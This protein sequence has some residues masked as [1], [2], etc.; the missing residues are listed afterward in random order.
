MDEVRLR[1]RSPTFQY[2]NKTNIN[3]NEN[4]ST[5]NN[6][7]SKAISGINDSEA[8]GN[9]NSHHNNSSTDEKTEIAPE[10]NRQTN[11][12]ETNNAETNNTDMNNNKNKSK[13]NSEPSS[14]QSL[15]DINIDEFFNNL[16][17]LK[18]LREI[19]PI[20]GLAILNN[21]INNL[22]KLY[23]LIQQGK[24]KQESDKNGNY[25][26]NT[27][28]NTVFLKDIIFP[29]DHNDSN[30][31][32]LNRFKQLL[33]LKTAMDCNDSSNDSLLDSES[34][35]VDDDNGFESDVDD[36]L[37]GE[38]V[39]NMI[40]NDNDR[41]DT[42]RGNFYDS[43]NST[44]SSGHLVN[45]NDDLELPLK[46]I[47]KIHS[48]FEELTQRR[49]VSG[50]SSQAN[51]NDINNSA[52]TKKGKNKKTEKRLEIIKSYNDRYLINKS[53]THEDCL[54]LINRFYLKSLP[55]LPVEKYL[56]RINQF[57]SSSASVYITASMYLFN[58]AFNLKSGIK[59]YYKDDSKN[60]DKKDKYLLI[61]PL[62]SPESIIRM[63]PIEDL[64]IFRLI[65][66]SIRISSKLIEDKNYKQNYYCKITGLQ[67][68]N[69]LF[70]LELIFLFIIDFN[71]ITNEILILRHLYQLKLFNNNLKN[72]I[73]SIN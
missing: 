42:S 72:F 26:S 15:E 1:T 7:K 63:I 44:L 56:N 65:L 5:D 37:S 46:K 4:E 53:R 32:K 57:I 21:T 67:N 60:Y 51:I 29:K 61:N 62:K 73:N 12:I 18:D 11:D 45:N 71:L 17:D 22:K 16:D 19:K 28:T 25:D 3:I 69:E 39:E 10:P 41:P 2:D 31:I 33:K 68:T 20:E 8:T 13:N 50:N 54:Q 55:S 48:N 9:S 66:T 47:S 59:S 52:I 40:T 64:N 49:S 58:I 36:S 70:K 23:S 24:I 35:T 14:R 30:E 38:E 43:S 6:S 27:N 34:E